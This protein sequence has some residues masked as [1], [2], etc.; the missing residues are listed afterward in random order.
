MFWSLGFS[1]VVF[2][3][4]TIQFGFEELPVG[5][6]PPFVNVVSPNPW[7]SSAKVADAGNS[8]G[9]PLFEGQK[10]LLGAGGISLASPDGQL[11]Q[12]FTLHI[13]GTGS[14]GPVGPIFYIAGQPVP[15]NGAWLTI[16]GSFGS[17]VQTI[18]ISDFVSSEV[19]PVGFGI[20]SV[21]FVT[22]PEPRTLWLLAFG[23]IFLAR[24]FRRRKANAARG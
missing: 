24:E 15:Q 10:F 23:P 6:T 9:I 22:I 8:Y 21:Q 11:I 2:A 16:Q 17:P 19:F 18:N 20:D 5:S 1:S 3:Q 7:V 4:D 14:N 12:S 13:F